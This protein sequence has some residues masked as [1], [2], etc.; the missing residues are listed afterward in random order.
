MQRD[1]EC[2]KFALV[3]IEV[4]SISDGGRAS[5]KKARNWLISELGTIPVSGNYI[6]F[7]WQS[8]SL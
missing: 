2:D 1:A 3:D 4:D 5:V 7:R 6:H 8:I